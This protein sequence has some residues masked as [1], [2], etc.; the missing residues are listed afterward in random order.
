MSY[1]D[2][3]YLRVT[4]TRTTAAG[5]SVRENRFFDDPRDARNFVRQNVNSFVAV[6]RLYRG[7]I[8]PLTLDELSALAHAAE[9]YKLAQVYRA[10]SLVFTGGIKPILGTTNV[11]SATS[12]I[13]AGVYVTTPHSC[14]C[15]AGLHGEKVCYHRIAAELLIAVRPSATRP[16]AGVTD[17]VAD[18]LADLL[19]QDATSLVET[20]TPHVQLLTKDELRAIHAHLRLELITA[21][22]AR[23]S[24]PHMLLRALSAAQDRS[25][26]IVAI[27]QGHGDH[28]N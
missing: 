27:L 26:L 22:L 2:D 15:V 13:G 10:R 17:Q 12:S 21:T 1:T 16:K 24:R 23:S 8:D 19:R 25:H 7:D 14:T 5:T 11:Y 6:K 4:Y 28:T 9:T 18:E 20:I 3:H